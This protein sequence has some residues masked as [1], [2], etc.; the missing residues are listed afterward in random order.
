MALTG[1]GKLIVNM[2]NVS[3]ATTL[4]RTY[5]CCIVWTLETRSY[6]SKLV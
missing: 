5:S 3:P 1:E 4:Q 2:Y 6:V